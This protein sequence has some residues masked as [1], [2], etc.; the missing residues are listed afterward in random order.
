MKIK[1]TICIILLLLTITALTAGCISSTRTGQSESQYVEPVYVG[2][3]QPKE[4]V[5]SIGEIMTS[6][7]PT[8]N[9][10]WAVTDRIRGAK[11]NAIVESG[12]MF[13]TK[14][15]SGYE[16]LLYKVMVKNVG[17]DKYTI[18]P[19]TWE[20]YADGVE[21]TQEWVILP[22]KYD[23]LGYIDIMPGASTSGWICTQVPIGSSVRIYFEPLFY[24][25]GMV[26]VP[27]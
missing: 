3:A 22:D 15:Y 18:Y 5:G 11:A 10:N 21:Q 26:Y 27:I 9:I 23:E 20:A 4:V 8:Y 2:Y 13:N 7:S 25:D 16:Y 19:P 6:K 12:N 17:T 1:R 24:D 14:P